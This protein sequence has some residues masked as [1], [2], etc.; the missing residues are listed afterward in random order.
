[1]YIHVL[2]CSCRSLDLGKAFSKSKLDRRI[3]MLLL[4]LSTDSQDVVSLCG[5][6]SWLCI[7]AG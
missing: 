2:M 4:L 5:H 7:S 3:E 1:M 6:Q